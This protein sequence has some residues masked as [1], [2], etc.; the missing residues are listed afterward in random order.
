MFL[1]RD[2]T[3]VSRKIILTKYLMHIY[4][5]VDHKK[6]KKIRGLESSIQTRLVGMIIPNTVNFLRTMDILQRNICN[7]MMKSRDS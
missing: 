6:N 1:T 4:F 7:K 5:D 3:K 2:M